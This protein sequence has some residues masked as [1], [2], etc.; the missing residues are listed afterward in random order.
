M[1]KSHPESY[2]HNSFETDDPLD[3]FF[4]DITDSGNVA[5]YINWFNRQWP[6]DLRIQGEDIYVTGYV[7]IMT[8]YHKNLVQKFNDEL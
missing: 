3:K 5:M 7:A 8:I 4:W 6:L 1:K 2:P